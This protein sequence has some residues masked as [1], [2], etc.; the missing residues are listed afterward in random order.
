MNF[1]NYTSW[2]FTAILFSALLSC[3]KVIDLKF[4]NASGRLVIEGSVINTPGP[5]VVQLTSNV[6]FSST[7]TYPPVQ[8]ALVTISDEN[9]NI[10][11]LPEGPVGTYA[12]LSP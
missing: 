1:Y 6:P 2:L 3:T 10:Y 9:G 7:N 5:Q 11:N 8:G 12:V 4:G